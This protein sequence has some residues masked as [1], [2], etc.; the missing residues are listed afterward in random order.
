MKINYIY[1]FKIKL[2][3]IQIILIL[4]TGTCFPFILFYQIEDSIL[5]KRSQ[6]QINKKDINKKKGLNLY[7]INLMREK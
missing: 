5:S 7:Y 3:S 1:I 6:K 2:F 4:N